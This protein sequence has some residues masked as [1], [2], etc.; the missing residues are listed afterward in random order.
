MADCVVGYWNYYLVHP[1]SGNRIEGCVTGL[2]EEAIVFSSLSGG[3]TPPGGLKDL[4]GNVIKSITGNLSFWV[5]Y[6]VAWSVAPVGNESAR[7]LAMSACSSYPPITNGDDNEDNSQ[8]QIDSLNE[9]I[10]DLKDRVN[11]LESTAPPDLSG[12]LL[13]SEFMSKIQENRDSIVLI[14]RDSENWYP[15]EIDL[16]GYLMDSED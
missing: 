14:I 5:S 11:A 15:V 9:E 13:K 16:S 10:D 8:A 12:Y 6:G 1:S 4:N 3:N 7:D 2:E